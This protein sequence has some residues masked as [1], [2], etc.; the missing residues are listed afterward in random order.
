MNG[1]RKQMD[2]PRLLIVVGGCIFIFILWLSAYFE[3]DIRWLHFFQAWM[4]L[5]AIG[6]S[7]GNNRWGYFIGISA[8]G[9]WEYMNLFVTTFF[10]NGLHWLFAWM[11]T[12]QLKHEDQIIAVPAWIGNFLVVLGSIWAYSRLA[13]KS[14]TDLA[15]FALAFLLS[16]GFFYLDVAVCQPRYLPLFR[17]MLHPHMLW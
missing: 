4:Y 14:G 3:R 2:L 13:K 17:G 12:G 6:L 5:A 11:S 16:T 8:A 15:R 7:L 9:L 1:V 10:R